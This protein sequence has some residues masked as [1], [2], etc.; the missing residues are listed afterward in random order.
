[1]DVAD[2]H[3]APL[4]RHVWPP[5]AAPT[6]AFV[7]LLWKSLRYIQFEMQVSRCDQAGPGT[8]RLTLSLRAHR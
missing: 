8:S 5:A 1:M 7:G 4:Y 2:M 3:V 6:L